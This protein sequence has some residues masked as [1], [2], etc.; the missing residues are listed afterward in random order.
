MST[1]QRDPVRE[2][3]WRKRVRSWQTS[4]LTIR[5]FCT[6]HG[7]AETAFQ[8]WRRELRERDAAFRAKPASSTKSHVR[9]R[10][11]TFVPVAVLPNSEPAV[12]SVATMPAGTIEIRCPSGHVV[13]TPAGDVTM[14]RH[15]FAALVH[16]L[17]LGGEVPSCST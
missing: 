10:R 3:L 1:G 11:P 12:A 14:L 16:P 17:P 9:S 4:G 7:L 6:R 8:H 13:V 5:Q 2:G 15:L